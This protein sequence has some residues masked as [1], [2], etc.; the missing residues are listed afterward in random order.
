VPEK[1]GL[2][3]P[4]SLDL[5]QS[6]LVDLEDRFGVGDSSRSVNQIQ[7]PDTQFALYV[8]ENQVY[9]D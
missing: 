2:L 6:L 3:Y 1:I 8:F 7:L 5:K 9:L 4:S